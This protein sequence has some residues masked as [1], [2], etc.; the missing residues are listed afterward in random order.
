MTFLLAKDDHLL[1]QTSGCL[2]TLVMHSKVSQALLF[3]SQ[4][5]PIG[6]NRKSMLLQRLLEAPSSPLDKAKGAQENVN[7][8]DEQ[9][10]ANSQPH[11]VHQDSQSSL[12]ER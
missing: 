2:L 12:K 4:M 10:E 6:I 11:L 9:S 5:F 7:G 3:H 8:A 1:L